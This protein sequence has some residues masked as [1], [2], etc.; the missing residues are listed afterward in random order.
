M[1]DKILLVI[2]VTIAMLPFVKAD[3]S[4]GWS[5]LPTC[6]INQIWKGDGTSMV[7]QADATGGAGGG[8]N[9][10][11]PYLYNDS[12]TMFWNETKG[13]ITYVNTDGDTMTDDLTINANL[14]VSG[15]Q[16][17]ADNLTISGNH[18]LNGGGTDFLGKYAMNVQS[19]ATSVFDIINTG[20]GLASLQINNIE[21]VGADS[22]VNK[23]VVEDSNLWDLAYTHSQ[24]NTQAHSDYILNNADDITTGKL[25]I[26]GGSEIGTGVNVL[27]VSSAGKL[28]FDGT[29]VYAV[30]SNQQAFQS[31]ASANA[32]LWFR[33]TGGNRYAFSNTGANDIFTIYLTG[34]AVLTDL[35]N[36]IELDAPNSRI[37]I[38]NKNGITQD[39]ILAQD[40]GGTCYLNITGGIIT[41]TD[42]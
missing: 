1:I 10:G 41:G 23:A 28:T 35:S 9:A 18:F 24:D 40:G 31:E 27:N 11:A 17:I 37:E 6:P 16:T 32:G 12:T 39:I 8:L 3:Y 2:I 20:T 14:F 13:N 26:R 21:I 34:R 29:G 25:I 33:T 19:I 4:A 22:E 7:C 15:R 38:N 36:T 30:R 42:C 5:L